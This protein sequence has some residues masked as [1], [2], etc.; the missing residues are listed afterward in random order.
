[1]I[2]C[3]ADSYHNIYQGL[4]FTSKKRDILVYNLFSIAEFKADFDISLKKLPKYLREV[5]ENEIKGQG[6]YDPL[7]YKAFRMMADILNGEV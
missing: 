7:L 1:M 4:E 5:V 3:I 6:R 2:G